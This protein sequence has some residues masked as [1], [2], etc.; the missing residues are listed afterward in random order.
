MLLA[1]CVKPDCTV[2]YAMNGNPAALFRR[3]LNQDMMAQWMDM[4]HNCASVF[5]SDEDQL[6]SWSLGKKSQF[7]TKSVYKFLEEGL[8]ACD[9]IWI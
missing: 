4:V 7:S 8:H 3:R 1:L 6:V 2:S 5:A 9:C